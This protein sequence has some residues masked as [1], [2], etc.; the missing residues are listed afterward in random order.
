MLERHVLLCRMVDKLG[1]IRGRTRFQKMLFVAKDLGYPIPENFA[2]GNYGVYSADLQSELDYLSSERFLEE[3]NVGSSDRPEFEY[4]LSEKGQ[5][6][7]A[8]SQRLAS[9]D[10]EETFPDPKYEGV[11]R[12]FG[13]K[14]LQELEN[15]LSHLNDVEISTLELWS[16]IKYLQRSERDRESLVSFLQYLK[17]RFSG[18]DIEEAMESITS[19][20]QWRIGSAETV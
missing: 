5:K 8:I 3:R 14:E 13:N 7:L 6:L 20:E 11:F 16:S 15:A 12:T 19:L 1:S 4:R 2:W 18:P 17:P 9:E 10:D